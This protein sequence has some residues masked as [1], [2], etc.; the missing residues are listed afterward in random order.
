MSCRTG[1]GKVRSKV[2]HLHRPLLDAIRY[3]TFACGAN[4]R[5]GMGVDAVHAS[6]VTCPKCKDHRS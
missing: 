2:V 1:C 5:T 3:A 4:S 6:Q